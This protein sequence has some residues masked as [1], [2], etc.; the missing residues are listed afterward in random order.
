MSLSLPFR[1]LAVLGALFVSEM[2]AQDIPAR[3]TECEGNQCVAGGGGPGI[4]TFNRT[5]GRGR[6]PG[7]G[8]I[9]N[10]SV[11]RWDSGIVII[12]RTDTAG[13]TPGITA[14]YIGKIQGNRVDGDVTWAW[15]GHWSKPAVGKWYATIEAPALSAAMP[16]RPVP[17][18]M[19]E[20]EGGQCVPGGGG[21]GIWVFNGAEGRAQWPL[22]GA[23]ANLTVE[24]F[25][26]DG[27]VIRRIDFAGRTPGINALYTGKMR[28]NRIEGDVTWSWP[29]HWNKSPSGKWSATVMEPTNYSILDP[30][31][32]CTSTSRVSADEALER[33]VQ[34]V[35]AKNAVTGSCWLRISARQGNANAQGFLAAI[36]YRG[37]GVP[38]NRPEAVVWA[39][40]ASEQGNYVGERCLSLIYGN[41]DGLPKDPSKAEYW[42]AKAEQDKLASIQ[43][44]Q[45][46]EDERK[47]EQQAIQ[48]AMARQSQAQFRQ[49]LQ[50]V[51]MFGLILGAIAGDSD[52]SGGSRH[53]DGLDR[54]NALKESCAD[55]FT[56][57]CN[58]IGS[59]PPSDR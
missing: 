25:D 39:Q 6:W 5:E 41:G 43:A 30:N 56:S 13:R 58:L 23:A 18:K 52:S 32:S 2:L 12:H 27:I 24:R 28:G 57:S 54:Y 19:T 17:A 36:L 8:A 46:V 59:A 48:L 16:A 33:G 11:E 34:A 31:V 55:G 7:S 51:I 29:G 45:K 49:N 47:R 42:R 44:E 20:C 4:W 9:A 10:L 21:P 26:F 38:V 50:G 3:M 15:P 37:V 35:Q 22:Q 1:I 53:P 40:K 14:T